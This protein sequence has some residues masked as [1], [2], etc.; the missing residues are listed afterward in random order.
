MSPL[1][2]G[3]TPP[4]HPAGEDGDLLPV[5]PARHLHLRPVRGGQVRHARSNICHIVKKLMKHFNH[6]KTWWI[7]PCTLVQLLLWPAP[8]AARGGGPLPPLHRGHQGDCGQVRRGH[9]RHPA[10]GAHIQVLGCWSR[11]IFL[12]STFPLREEAVSVGPNHETPPVCL[13]CLQLVT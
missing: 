11:K 2:P 6:Q 12:L 9:P 3:T 1:L 8:G 4:K 13:V 5:R 7:V 10:G